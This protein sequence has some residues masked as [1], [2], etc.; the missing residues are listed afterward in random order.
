MS[1]CEKVFDIPQIRKLI[2]SYY[3][4]KS[5]NETTDIGCKAY[6]INIVYIIRNNWR[7]YI[8]DRFGIVLPSF[9]RET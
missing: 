3:L 8:L 5:V 9:L 7:T 2:L 6:I 4:N 1:S